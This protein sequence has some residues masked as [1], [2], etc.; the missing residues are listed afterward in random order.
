MSNFFSL[1]LKVSLLLFFFSFLFSRFCYQYFPAIDAI[2]CCNK[3][4]LYILWFN[5]LL[6]IYIPFLT[7]IVNL[8]YLLG[9]K[10]FTKIINYFWLVVHLSKFSLCTFKKNSQECLTRETGRNAQEFLARETGRNAQEYL[11][12]E[13]IQNTQEYLTKEIGQNAQEYLTKETGQNTQGYLTKE[14]V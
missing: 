11:T 1:M 14:T 7:Y 6:H 13:T 2:C 4:C 9:A 3:T 5:V 12:K 10:D 8:S